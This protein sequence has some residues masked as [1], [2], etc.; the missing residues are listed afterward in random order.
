MASHHVGSA[1]A[2]NGGSP[3][4]FD[5]W[6]YQE[7][8]FPPDWVYFQ[9]FFDWSLKLTF[10]FHLIHQS[11]E[12]L[13]LCFYYDFRFLQRVFVSEDQRVQQFSFSSLSEISSGDSK[14]IRVLDFFL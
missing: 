4:R 9:F 10:S 13:E 5:S 3:N 7:N 6:L 8:D 12:L 11:E 14:I 1:F 2:I